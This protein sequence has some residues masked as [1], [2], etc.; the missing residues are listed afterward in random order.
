MICTKSRTDG[1]HSKRKRPKG[2]K[3]IFAL[4]SY[5]VDEGSGRSD[6]RELRRAFN[7]WKGDELLDARLTGY[8]NSPFRKARKVAGS[9]PLG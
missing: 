9:R 1:K 3:S 2:A 6:L 5:K 8:R 4:A 7:Q